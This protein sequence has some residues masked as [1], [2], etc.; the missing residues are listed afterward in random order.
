M[1]ARRRRRKTDTVAG[2][3]QA[4]PAGSTAALSSLVVLIAGWCGLDLTAEQ[5]AIVIGGLTT[6]V[7][8]FTPRPPAAD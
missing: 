5:A 7:S 4:R 6:L 3:V 8:L 1:P 2:N